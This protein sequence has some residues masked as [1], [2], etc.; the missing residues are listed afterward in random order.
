MILTFSHAKVNRPVDKKS[1]NIQ[2]GGLLI[3]LVT[4]YWLYHEC[5][6]YLNQDFKK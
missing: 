5:V 6:P 2:D 4:E 1:R 3:V